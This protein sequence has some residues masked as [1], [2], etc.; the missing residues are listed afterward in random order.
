MRW[1]RSVTVLITITVEILE[2]DA[3]QE[4]SSRIAA[5]APARVNKCQSGAY[6]D[7]VLVLGTEKE[8][9]DRVYDLI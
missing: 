7:D 5:N 1:S 8:E 3:H 9:F 2:C 6:I 4:P